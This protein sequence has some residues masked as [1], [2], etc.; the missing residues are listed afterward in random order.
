[1][2][3]SMFNLHTAWFIFMSNRFLSIYEVLQKKKNKIKTQRQYVLDTT[4]YK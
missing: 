1:M 2:Q 4:K 3:F